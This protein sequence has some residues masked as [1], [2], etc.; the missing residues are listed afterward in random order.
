MDELLLMWEKA[1]H[2]DQGKYPELFQQFY[3]PAPSSHAFVKSPECQTDM[4]LESCKE[5]CSRNSVVLKRQLSDFLGDGLFANDI[6]DETKAILDT[7]P[8]TNL[9]GEHLLGDPD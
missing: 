9:S 7:C 1:N 2:F 3:K 4:A 8:L 6:P 5:I